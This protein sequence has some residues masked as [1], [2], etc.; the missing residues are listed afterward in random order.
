MAITINGNGTITGFSSGAL[1]TGSVIQVAST[2]IAGGISATGTGAKASGLITTVTPKQ[3]NSK[4]YVT[5]HNIT[6]HVNK[7]SAQNHGTEYYLYVSVDGGAYANAAS[8]KLAST[9]ISGDI[10]AWADFPCSIGYLDTPS[11]SLGETVAYQ[12][13]F[14]KG[15]TTGNSEAFY[16]NH[17][18]GN[19]ANAR[20]TQTVMEI[21]G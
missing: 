4:F 21:A 7:S 2:E 3:A 13:Y 17:V 10:G 19:G 12:P 1:P 9:Y 8:N 5:I 11:Y 16:F 14:E 6:A 18:G 15:A 20:V